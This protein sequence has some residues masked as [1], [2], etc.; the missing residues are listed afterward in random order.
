VTPIA[1]TRIVNA[2]VLVELGGGSI[3]TD[4]YFDAHWFMRFDEPIGVAADQLP[5]LAAI[6]GG[7]GAFD[8]W[9]PRSLR[10]YRYHSATAVY[11]AN[12][13]MARSAR[14]AGFRRVEVLPWGQQRKLGSDLTVTSLPGERIAGMRTN[15]YLV[16]SGGTGVFV[17][18]EARGLEVIEAVA[19]RH[20]IDVAVLP[21]NGARLLGRRLVMDAATACRAAELLGAQTLVPIHYSQRPIPPILTTRSRVDDLDHVRRHPTGVRVE[22]IPAGERRQIDIDRDTAFAARPQRSPRVGQREDF[23]LVRPAGKARRPGR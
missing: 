2:T 9:Q 14:R 4:P 19:A 18:T 12:D 20:R 15:H 6:V 17:G 8:H 1:I 22:I 3:L 13:R 10:S 23:G 16:S 5:P 7:H 21:I 11:V